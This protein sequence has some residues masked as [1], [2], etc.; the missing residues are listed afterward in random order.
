MVKVPLGIPFVHDI[1]GNPD[2]RV[3]MAM[4]HNH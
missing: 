1:D 3:T 4:G 2:Q